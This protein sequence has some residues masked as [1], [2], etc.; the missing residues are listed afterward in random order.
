MNELVFV[1]EANEVK[2]RGVIYLDNIT[3]RRAWDDL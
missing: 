1:F 3:L 2:K